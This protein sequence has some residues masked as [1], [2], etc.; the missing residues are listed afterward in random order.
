MTCREE[1]RRQTHERIKKLNAYDRKNEQRE[2]G[3]ELCR[4]MDVGSPCADKMFNEG[5]RQKDSRRFLIKT[6][7]IGDLMLQPALRDVGIFPFITFK[8]NGCERPAQ[9]QREA[10]D[11][12]STEQIRYRTR[13]GYLQLAIMRSASTATGFIFLGPC[14]SW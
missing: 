6:V 4:P 11:K 14:L 2:Q 9:K 1:R 5:I 10:K 12:K 13:D 7:S 3:V 8:R